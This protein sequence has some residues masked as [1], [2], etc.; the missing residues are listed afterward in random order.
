MKPLQNT[1]NKYL[2]FLF[3]LATFIFLPAK[4]FADTDL[5]DFLNSDKFLDI[6]LTKVSKYNQLF[7][8]PAS[9]TMTIEAGNR[10]IYSGKTQKITIQAIK[11][12]QM[13][14]QIGSEKSLQ[15]GGSVKIIPSADTTSYIQI[16][17]SQRTSFSFRG[18]ITVFSKNSTL[19]IINS[20]FIEDYLKS[21]VPSEIPPSAPLQAIEAQTVAARTYAI[22]NFNQHKKD[23]YN[24]CDSVHCQAYT[25][26]AKEDSRTTKG[27]VNSIARI[28]LAPSTK[29]PANTVY[30]SNCGG[31]LI[32]S[33]A[34]WGGKAVSYLVGH[35]D[36]IK[37]YKPFCYF[38]NRYFKKQS[39]SGMP[40]KK[41]KLV[42]GVTPPYAKQ[43]LF[44]SSGHRVGMCQDGAT[45][46]AACGY[47]C[48]QILKFYYPGTQ[49]VKLN[50]G[51]SDSIRLIDDSYNKPKGTIA[52]K[53]SATK[54]P[55]SAIT[56]ALKTKDPRILTTVS[57][58]KQP[59]ILTKSGK[60]MIKE[61]AER[62]KKQQER[63]KEAEKAKLK[64]KVEEIKTETLKKIKLP[65]TP[66]TKKVIKK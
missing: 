9:E 58:T 51:L 57:Q 4:L 38:G 27:V 8:I 10:Q 41:Q 18:N 66:A 42:V 65:V 22:R 36:G 44:P 3:S 48:T 37:G 14:L 31:Y 39:L 29:E 55:L 30:H 40:D 6:A 52:D 53:P 23:N 43:K 16:K 47:S 32:S 54:D 24:L 11:G 2:F 63:E 19:K 7:F 62:I 12:N 1:F 26:I 46:M 28:L 34:A 61:A 20:V 59:E 45:G 64:N 49:L 50:Y 13:K 15:L 21:V 17:L 60:D 33:Q 5:R 56:D 25:G 35:Y